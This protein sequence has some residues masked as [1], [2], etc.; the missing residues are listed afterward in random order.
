[1]SRKGQALLISSKED[2]KMLAS[3]DMEFDPSGKVIEQ[4]HQAGESTDG[5]EAKVQDL[6]D[7]LWNAWAAAG[8]PGGMGT[9]NVDQSHYC[10]A[11]TLQANAETNKMLTDAEKRDRPAGTSIFL[12]STYAEQ[13][14]G[15][16]KSVSEDEQTSLRFKSPTLMHGLFW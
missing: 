15:Q 14:P 12:R 2:A 7:D 4:P 8:R 1:M 9:S 6:V 16:W 5:G 13:S 11:K 10:L 3:C